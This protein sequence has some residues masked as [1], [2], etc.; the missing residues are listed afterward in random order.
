[1]VE[2]KIDNGDVAQLVA[3]TK[4][5]NTVST[6]LP[7]YG[8]YVYT[9]SWWYV[10]SLTSYQQHARQMIASEDVPSNKH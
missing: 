1:M 3:L 2:E 10:E 5:N 4:N 9:L 6:R 8:V 7:W